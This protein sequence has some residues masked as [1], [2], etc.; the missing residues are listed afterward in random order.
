[1]ATVLK[2]TIKISPEL[3]DQLEELVQDTGK[4][5][6]ELVGEALAGYIAR[7]KAIIA[8]VKEGR[9]AAARGELVD[10]DDVEA[11]LDSWGTENE[12]PAPSSKV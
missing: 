2:P 8:K 3:K 12:L 5:E 11:W 6:A 7:Q 1:M 4:S 9:A 10:Q